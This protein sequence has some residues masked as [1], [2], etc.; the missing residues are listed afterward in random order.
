MK[1]ETNPKFTSSESSDESYTGTIDI[2]SLRASLS[3]LKPEVREEYI[4]TVLQITI[5]NLIGLNL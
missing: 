2:E 3:G 4:K 5:K 1:Y